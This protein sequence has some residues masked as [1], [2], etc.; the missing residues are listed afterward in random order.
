VTPEA[1][2]R[3]VSAWQAGEVPYRTTKFDSGQFQRVMTSEGVGP[4]TLWWDQIVGKLQ[5]AHVLGLE[6]PNGRQ[7]LA[8][9]GAAVLALLEAS[10][11]EYGLLPTPGVASGEYLGRLMPIDITETGTSSVYGL[12]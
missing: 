3:Y 9:C 7:A 5:R 10:V 12:T 1:S 2:R 4:G 8:K 11:R 6:T